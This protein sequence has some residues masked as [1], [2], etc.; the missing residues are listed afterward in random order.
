MAIFNNVGHFS[1][2]SIGYKL[3]PTWACLKPSGLF[4]Q[5]YASLLELIETVKTYQCWNIF[6]VK[7]SITPTNI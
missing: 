5:S 7:K 6:L 1:I 3:N 4:D 2:K